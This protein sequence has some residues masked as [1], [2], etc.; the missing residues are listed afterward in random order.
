[1]D[2]Q[3]TRV[4]LRE[5]KYPG[6]AITIDRRALTDRSVFDHTDLGNQSLT[7]MFPIHEPPCIVKRLAYVFF[8]FKVLS[9]LGNFIQQAVIPALP[10]KVYYFI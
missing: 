5:L 2:A 10:R 8:M 6:R 7:V 1:V 3:F 9:E 4:L